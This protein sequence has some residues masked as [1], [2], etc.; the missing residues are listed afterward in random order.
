MIKAPTRQPASFVFGDYENRTGWD[1]NAYVILIAL[2]QAQYTLTG[3]D[4][5]AHMTEETRNAEIA[6]PVGMVMAIV[7]STITGFIFIIGFLFCIQNLEDTIA[8]V[9]GFPGWPLYDCIDPLLTQIMVDC[10]GN[11]GA[12]GLM[13]VAMGACWFCGFASVTANSRMIYV[14]IRLPKRLIHDPLLPLFWSDGAMPGNYIYVRNRYYLKREL[15]LIIF[16]LLLPFPGSKLWHTINR[17]I[18]TPLNAVWLAVFAA[19]ILALPVRTWK[20][21]AWQ[22]ANA[23]SP[24]NIFLCDHST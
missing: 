11:G 10:L 21:T 23:I 9:T 7:V 13:I 8:T 12:I 22:Q 6:G 18:D 14:S 19:S 1:S 3:Y 17:K 15:C 4:S 20:F 5:S 2:L 16:N 24:S